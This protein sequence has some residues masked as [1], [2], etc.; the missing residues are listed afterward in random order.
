MTERYKFVGKNLSS[1]TV[2][3]A[4]AY[5]KQQKAKYSQPLEGE[6]E[7]TP[8]QLETIAL[9]RNHLTEYMVSLDLP[10]KMVLEEQRIH[11]LNHDQFVKETN[12]KGGETGTF[13]TITQSICV[14]LSRADNPFRHY[15]V[16]I[17]EGSHEYSLTVYSVYISPVNGL[18]RHLSEYRSGY[19]L[20][21]W[22]ESNH[23]HFRDFHEA[24][25][26][27]I[28]IDVI[29]RHHAEL[30][31]RW[32]IEPRNST[33]VYAYMDPLEVFNA[34]TRGVAR[35]R[36]GEKLEDQTKAAEQ[37]KREVIRKHV[38]GGLE[39]LMVI[40][41]AFGAGSLRFLAAAKTGF[42]PMMEI[43]ANRKILRYFESPSN[44]ERV[45]IALSTLN[46]R[47]RFRYLTFRKS[48][49]LR[50]NE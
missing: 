42:K 37:F 50:S 6:E 40:D 1:D 10:E 7:K 46:E 38:L 44:E 12:L 11:F 14:D 49:A 35:F 24:V 30:F 45:S 23:F 2:N 9:A 28:A 8:E 16:L 31:A 48:K 15:D 29:N 17:H 21:H 18:F 4:T 33:D 26:E 3:A 19:S 25:T 41:Q 47:E 39:Y 13:R 34:I 27:R 32:P 20:E 5:L 22:L 36:G 43:E